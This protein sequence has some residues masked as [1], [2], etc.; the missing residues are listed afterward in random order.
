MTARGETVTVEHVLQLRRNTCILALTL[1]VLPACEGQPASESAAQGETEG[2]VCLDDL[3]ACI[4][5]ADD[6]KVDCR[7]DCSLYGGDF[8][9]WRG[10]KEQCSYQSYLD[11]I[12]CHD[13]A[14]CG[15]P[16]N[17]WH[18]YAAASTEAS[19]CYD[20]CLNDDDRFCYD[21]LYEANRE[22]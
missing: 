15:E 8:C 17:D 13:E 10:C 2:Q 1:A 18:C 7:E 19:A 12:S 21:Q 22:C 11:K 16:E 5:I 3:D 14:Q 4:E 20:I 6:D 9:A